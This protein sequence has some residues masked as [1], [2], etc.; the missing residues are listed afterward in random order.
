MST[1][2]EQTVVDYEQHQLDML[3]WQAHVLKQ[4]G[5]KHE[6]SQIRAWVANFR[7]PHSDQAISEETDETQGALKKAPAKSIASRALLLLN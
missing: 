5:K 2:S 7:S 3:L 1:I 4:N 6:A